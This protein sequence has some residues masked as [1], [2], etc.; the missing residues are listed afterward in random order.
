[1]YIGGRQAGGPC[2]SYRGQM[3]GSAFSRGREGRLGPPSNRRK[4]PSPGPGKKGVCFLQEKESWEQ[5]L[6]DWG[7]KGGVYSLGCGDSTG[8]QR[9]SVRV[10]VC[11]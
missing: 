5:V 2:A 11:V 6:G 4:K 1:M 8:G 7:G 3:E 9:R 10:C